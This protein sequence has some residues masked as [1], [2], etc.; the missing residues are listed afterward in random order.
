MLEPT[1]LLAQEEALRTIP[2]LPVKNWSFRDIH[3]ICYCSCEKAY[4][5]TEY[6]TLCSI[7]ECLYASSNVLPAPQRLDS[8]SIGDTITHP[9]RRRELI[10]PDAVIRLGKVL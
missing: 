1:Y 3:T 2:I 10:V 5:S 9:V 8:I 6:P 7:K 4:K